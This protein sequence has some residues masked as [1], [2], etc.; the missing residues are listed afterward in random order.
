M[1]KE[2]LVPKLRFEEFWRDN[3]WEL[4]SLEETVDIT[5]GQSPSSKNYTNNPSDYILVQGNSDLKNGKVFPRIWTTQVTKKANKGDLI[6]SV[7]AP[8]GDVGKTD[9]DVVLGRGVAAITGNEFIYQLL[10]KMKVNNYW[11]NLIT[12]STFES[13]NSNDIKD[14]KLFFP[15]KEEQ[16]KIGTFFKKFDKMIQL[17]QSKVN[18]V[19]D[20]KSAYLS[21]MFPKEGEKYPKRRFEGFTEPWKKR[22]LDS[23]ANNFDMLRIPVT[24]ADRIPGDTPYYGANGIQDYV[25]GHT[26]DG[27]YILLAEDGAND[28]KNYPVHFVN[29]KVW[30]NNH[31]HVLQG[32]NGVLNNKFLMYNLKTIDMEPYLVGGGRAKLNANIMMNIEL[33]LPKLEEQSKIGNFFKNLDN[34]ISIEEEKLIKLEKLKQAYLNDM[35]V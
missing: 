28:L 14:A 5:M 17:Q 10:T 6:L 9:F 21:E 30:V 31:A 20:I 23:I 15:R 16:N 34:Q 7:R 26:H 27:E 4:K 18:K 8:V 13:I 22:K 29:G 3:I 11:T 24:A 2:K 12:G 35:F 25:E 1:S 32:N 33:L 19:K